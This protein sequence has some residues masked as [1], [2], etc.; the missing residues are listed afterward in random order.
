[1]IKKRNIFII[2]FL[3]FVMYI[4]LIIFLPI[5]IKYFSEIKRGNKII[6]E[7]ENYY[8]INKKYPEEN[9][10]RTIENIYR[11]TFLKNNIEFNG[12]TIQPYYFRIHNDYVLEYIMGFDPPYLYYYSKIKEWRYGY[13][14][15]DGTY[16]W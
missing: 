9:D 16:E 5:Q 14:S 2:L 3:L 8:Y 15:R 4:I 6:K 13:L 12:M 1:M 11:N 7:L 10:W